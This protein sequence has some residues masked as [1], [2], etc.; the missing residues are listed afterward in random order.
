MNKQIYLNFSGAILLEQE[1]KN[2]I[3]FI[4]GILDLDISML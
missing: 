2:K 3:T 1:L 4:D